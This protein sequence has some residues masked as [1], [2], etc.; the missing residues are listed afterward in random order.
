MSTL[1]VGTFV[2][3]E[4]HDGQLT[5]RIAPLSA[6]VVN[7]DR[8]CRANLFWRT[9]CRFVLQ[10]SAYHALQLFLLH[11]GTLAKSESPGA[12]ELAVDDK[13]RR[14]R[15]LV[16]RFKPFGRGHG[17]LSD[18]LLT[19]L[20]I[21]LMNGYAQGLYDQPTIQLTLELLKNGFLCITIGT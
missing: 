15:E 2:I 9:C 12:L 13:G 11:L 21:T 5:C 17:V 6:H 20:T 10:Q 18:S 14:T 7:L 8:R 3:I 4:G 19:D 1:C 16:L